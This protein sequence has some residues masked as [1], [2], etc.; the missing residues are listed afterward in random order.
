MSIRLTALHIYPL[1][2]CAA[3][4]PT[5]IEVE[6]RGLAH[7]RRWMIV[8]A[9][10][11]FIT[12]REQPRLVLI[13]A[14]PTPRGLLLRAPGLPDL[15]VAP[16]RASAERI[17]VT[18]WRSLVDAAL[19]SDEAHTWVSRFLRADCKLVYM[20]ASAAR[21]V[22]PEYAQPGDEVSFADAYPLL[23]ISQGSLAALNAKLHQ[24]VSMLRFRPNLVIDGVPAHAEDGWKRMRVGKIEF[25][26]LKPCVR[27]GFTTVIPETGALDPRGEPLRTL[28]NYRRGV[29]GVQGVI[30]GMNV[31][32]RGRGRMT[33]G[34][35]V[36]VL[37]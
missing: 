30:F 21:P 11:R 29:K 23:L 19:A 33:V 22:D 27:C 7:D 20:D 32:A 17:E 37:S 24:P 31:I 8:D 15:L 6:T 12:G 1:K 5:Q 14:E 10:R 13:R 25:E 28:A 2:S 34:D 4:A 16:P 18:V 3:L 35:T 36:E 26:L 9:G